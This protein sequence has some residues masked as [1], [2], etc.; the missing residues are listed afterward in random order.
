LLSVA[1]AHIIVDNAPP[2]HF[3]YSLG[4]YLAFHGL[5]N[6]AL[7]TKVRGQ[8]ASHVS[9]PIAGPVLRIHTLAAPPSHPI[10]SSSASFP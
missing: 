1:P 6:A 3:G 7:K 4:Y 10:L 2:L 8:L 5:G 9:H